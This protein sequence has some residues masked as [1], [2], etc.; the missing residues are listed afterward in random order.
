MLCIFRNAFGI[1]VKIT[2]LIVHY[3]LNSALNI[4]CDYL[5]RIVS[6]IIEHS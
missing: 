2:E 3:T 5:E 4:C 6:Q 1:T